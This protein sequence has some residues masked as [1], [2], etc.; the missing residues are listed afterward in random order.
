MNE[1]LKTARLRIDV[2]LL[3]FGKLKVS[4][5]AQQDLRAPIYSIIPDNSV[6]GVSTDDVIDYKWQLKRN[7]L[8]MTLESETYN[9]GYWNLYKEKGP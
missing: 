1:T 8:F 2:E 4:P 6:G 3:R 9:E 7:W 5:N